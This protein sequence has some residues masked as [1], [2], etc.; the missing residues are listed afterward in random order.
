MSMDAAA[1]AQLLEEFILDAPQ[2]A[3][4]EDGELL[5]DFAD[6]RYSLSTEHNRCLLHLWSAERNCVRRVV[7]AE[8]RPTAL[9]LTVQRFGKPQPTRMEIV[10]YRDRRSAST[11]KTARLNFQRTFARMLQRQFPGWTATGLTNSADL[12]HSFG[13]AYCRGMLRRGR[14]GWACIAV[15]EGESQAAID[16]AL[17]IGL[18]WLD[19]LRERHAGDLVIEG[20]KFFAPARSTAVIRMRAAHLNHDAAK[21]EIWEIS[22]RDATLEQKDIFDRGNIFSSLTRCPDRQRLLDRF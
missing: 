20:L 10:K 21:F 1:L 11:L 7:D 14:S 13:P 5:F 9:R 4:L 18:L 17:T 22:E 2:P 12:E 15:S 6:A 8:V 16:G 3:V 19:L